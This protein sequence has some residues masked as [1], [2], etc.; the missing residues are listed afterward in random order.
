M[1]LVEGRKR[2]DRADGQGIGTAFGSAAGQLFKGHA[3]AIATI[4]R[5]TQAV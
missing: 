1:V 4:A 5:A 3:V 2:V